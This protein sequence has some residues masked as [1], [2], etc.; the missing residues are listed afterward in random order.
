MTGRY[1]YEGALSQSLD[2]RHRAHSL[3]SQDE[4]KADRRVAKHR[5]VF[6]MDTCMTERGGA[7]YRLS[8]SS[9]NEQRRCSKIWKQFALLFDLSLGDAAGQDGTSKAGGTISAI[10]AVVAIVAIV[11]IGWRHSGESLQS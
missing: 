4:L 11:A 1:A 9:L 3:V 8:P 6:R 2:G 5:V 7:C 10:V